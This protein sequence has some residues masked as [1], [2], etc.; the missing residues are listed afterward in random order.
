[1]KLNT[2]TGIE[3]YWATIDAE[4]VA[5]AGMI[6]IRAIAYPNLGE[7]QVLAGTTIRN[8]Q[9]GLHSMFLYAEPSVAAPRQQVHV[10]LNGDD[11]NSGTRVSPFATLEQAVTAVED[12]GEI[13]VLDPGNYAAPYVNGG[14]LQRS[15][16]QWVTIRPDDGLRSRDVIIT[17]TEDIRAGLELV[18]WHQVT[19]DLA[20]RE[21]FSG[22]GT[23]W[24]DNVRVI[25]SN[26]WING[27][28]RLNH[29][30]TPYYATDSNVTDTLYGFTDGTLVRNC[31]AQRISGDAYQQTELLLN[32]TV[33]EMDD[34]LLDHHTDVYQLFGRTE[35]VIVYGLTAT[36]L[37][38]AVQPFFI[39][40]TM[41]QGMLEPVSNSAFVNITMSGT[42]LPRSQ[43]MGGIYRHVLFSNVMIPGS[44]MRIR[45]SNGSFA[46]DAE[47]VVFDT[48]HFA[49]VAIED[50]VTSGFVF[51]N[52]II[53]GE[54]YSFTL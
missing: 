20:H 36:N 41:E 34:D 16:E 53:D 7:P 8:S 22:F 9:D 3:E 18:R 33:D 26:G 45:D 6:E 19:F 2:R 29:Y 15:V 23:H 39:E 27:G 37:R 13:I 44:V 54:P 47:N 32:S 40:P 12:G 21:K 30:Q 31:H 46:M 43:L 48:F 10:S 52:G 5:E 1:M 42:D 28:G 4:L 14:H 35:N 11:T 25:D 38:N 49:G 50:G 17:S 24:L 51:L